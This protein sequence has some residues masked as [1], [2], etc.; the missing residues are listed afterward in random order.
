MTRRQLRATRVTGYKNIVMDAAG[1]IMPCCGAPRPDINLVFGKIEADGGDPFNS[2]DTAR[3]GHGSPAAL[4]L[5]M[6]DHIAR[7]ASGTIRP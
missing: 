6:T 3:L 5:P 7:G 2:E 4:P 1:R